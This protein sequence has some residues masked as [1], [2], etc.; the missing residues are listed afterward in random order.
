MR[1]KFLWGI[2]A[3]FLS[4]IS[5]MAINLNTK[6]AADNPPLK[7]IFQKLY[8]DR[9][10]NIGDSSK[11]WIFF[12]FNNIV[13]NLVRVDNDSYLRPALASGWSFSD[14]RKTLKLSISDKYKFHDGKT[15]TPE[16]VLF[17]LKRAFSSNLNF[18]EIVNSLASPNLEESLI[19]DGSTIEIR[20]K[21]P[22]N[23]LLY[24]L[25]IPELGIVPQDYAKE[26]TYKE[27]LNNFSGPYKVINFT[28]E[29]LSL[30]KHSGHPLLDEKSADRV[31]IFEI[32][33]VEESIEYYKKNDNVVLIGSGY[34]KVLKYINLEGEKYTSAPALTE[35]LLPNLKSPHLNTEKK[36]RE[37]FSTIKIAFNKVQIDGR[38]AERTNQI[39]TSNNL[40]R[41]EESQL[42]NLYDKNPSQ[43]PLKLSV[44]LFHPL[45]ENPIPFLIQEQ[46][47]PY[48][49]ELE[50]IT[51]D[52]KKLRGRVKK[53]D[54]D[55]YYFGS[56]VSAV[57]PIV[58]MIYLL[59]HPRYRISSNQV[60]K[61]ALERAKTE[62][63]REK[64]VSLL[65][66][67]HLRL[68]KEYRILPLM[69]TK[70]VYCAKGSYQLK[71][72]SHYDGGLNLWDWHKAQ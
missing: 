54:Y 27:S 15:I 17:S 19:L 25:S 13:E 60:I 8:Y 3:A 39:F 35:F 2:L 26:K 66:E 31:D 4:L 6:V 16:D 43:K 40:S 45:E 59:N 5:F 30:E 57:D 56:G 36:R 47:K 48:G 29:K 11:L 64:Y 65:K 71:D 18:A 52:N 46:L 53:N 12:A 62:T 63:E 67:I 23:A 55:F 69:H 51:G 44:L 38:I 58:G 42:K 1:K 49:I 14:D 21:K 10:W 33:S 72:L 68:L 61:N 50:I 9:S 37:V 70:M 7:V 41:L 34:E 24:K 22:L 28:P 20:L 32:P